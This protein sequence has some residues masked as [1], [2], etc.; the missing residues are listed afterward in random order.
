MGCLVETRERAGPVPWALRG[1]GQCRDVEV[2]GFLL[3]FLGIP[4]QTLR[5]FV[6]RDPCAVCLEVGSGTLVLPSLGLGSH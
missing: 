2:L 5:V 4:G 6:E 3:G 1:V